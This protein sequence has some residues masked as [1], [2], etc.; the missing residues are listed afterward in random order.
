MSLR[1]IHIFVISASI[2]LAIFFGYWS[3]RNFFDSRN[4]SSLYL[5]ALSL[6]VAM[7]L[8]PYIMWFFKK[9]KG[10]S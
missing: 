5:G 3:L 10:H 9:V 4:A 7:V 1:A 2:L 6:L 8:I